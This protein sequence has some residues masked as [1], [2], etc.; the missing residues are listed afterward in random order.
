MSQ[1]ANIA[2]EIKSFDSIEEVLIVLLK[3][4]CSHSVSFTFIHIHSLSFRLL[5][6]S[7]FE[8]MRGLWLQAVD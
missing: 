5:G 6:L 3:K 2:M 1:V 7:C 8:V 4:F